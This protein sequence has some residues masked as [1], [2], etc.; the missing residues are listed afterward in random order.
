MFELSILQ[1][2]SAADLLAFHLLKG[3]GL[4]LPCFSQC[5][6]FSLLTVNKMGENCQK[7]KFITKKW[8]C[9][10]GEG[11]ISSYGK[12]SFDLKRLLTLV[13]NF[14]QGSS[15]SISVPDFPGSSWNI[16]G[17]LFQGLISLLTDKTAMLYLWHLLYMMAT[18]KKWVSKG[19]PCEQEIKLQSITQIQILF[20]IHLVWANKHTVPCILCILSWQRCHLKSS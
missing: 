5:K 20:C 3:K 13:S 6:S 18:R 1:Q 16:A 2:W 15:K 9:F 14:I 10:W 11:K 8:Y 17:S 19:L 12:S 4:G 7:R